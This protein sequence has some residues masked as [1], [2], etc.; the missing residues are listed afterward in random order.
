MRSSRNA[1]P[2][3]VRPPMRSRISRGQSSPPLA[4]GIG[5]EPEGD[6]KALESRLQKTERASPVPRSPTRVEATI[7]SLI[8]NTEQH[9]AARPICP[10]MNPGPRSAAKLAGEG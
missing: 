4:R 6:A 2:K 3:G 7:P 1:D 10:R 9:S 5:P 8:P